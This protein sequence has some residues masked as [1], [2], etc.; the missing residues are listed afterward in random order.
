MITY[1]LST[2]FLYF[3]AMV[4]GNCNQCRCQSYQSGGPWKCICG[5]N[6]NKH[7][8]LEPANDVEAIRQLIQWQ[9][10][11]NRKVQKDITVNDKFSTL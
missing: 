2:D 6:Y 3:V 9:A 4:R 8:D 10:F 5:H 11:L 7:R 1:F